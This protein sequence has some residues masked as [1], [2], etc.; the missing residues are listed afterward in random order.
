MNRVRPQL[1]SL[2]ARDVPS[3]VDILTDVVDPNDGKTS[4][5]EAI[6]A[7]NAATKTDTINFSVTGLITL[8]SALPII[9][10]SLDIVG[11]GALSLSVSGANAFKMFNFELGITSSISGLTITGSG[12]IGINNNGTLTVSNCNIRGNSSALFG[13]IANNGSM[14]I[15]D[16][17]VSDNST[18]GIENNGMM[19][20]QG[21]TISGN[22]KV[23][24]VNASGITTKSLTIRD[25]TV[26]GNSL[27]GII[28][29]INLTAS[30]CTIVGNTGGPGFIEG[31]DGGPATLTNKP[32]LAIAGL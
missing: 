1:V 18:N 26:S 17:I 7:V 30:N 27:G 24:I 3:T 8:T 5:R 15:R 20:I 4:L 10:Q 19:T 9:T 14:T 25:S 16:C 28:N 29:T 21:S 11:P 12:N 23:G 6:I 31:K 32:L 22:S 2:E 13:A